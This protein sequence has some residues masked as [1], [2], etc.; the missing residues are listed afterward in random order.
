M[1][2]LKKGDEV[3]L[4]GFPEIKLVV[5]EVNEEDANCRYWC[6]EGF[7]TIRVRFEHLHSYKK[8]VSIRKSSALP[9]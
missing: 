7:K 5:F 1:T 3:S 8:K 2:D 9:Q 4:T 6:N